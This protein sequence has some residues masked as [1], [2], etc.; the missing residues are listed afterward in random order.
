[1][2]ALN[3]AKS[4]TVSTSWLLKLGQDDPTVPF[5]GRM[6]ADKVG[7]AQD[8]DVQRAAANALLFSPEQR[9]KILGQ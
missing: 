3:S 9:K 2:T 4:P 8:P 1:M 7:T 6:G 5:K